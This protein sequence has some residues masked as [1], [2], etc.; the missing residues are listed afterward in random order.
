MWIL[1]EW[2][3]DNYNEDCATEEMEGYWQQSRE[4]DWEWVRYRSSV[5]PDAAD[6]V[7]GPKR[8][9]TGRSASAAASDG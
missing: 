2:Y 1:G 5:D 6:N 7:D 4:G 9:R 3:E 8:Y